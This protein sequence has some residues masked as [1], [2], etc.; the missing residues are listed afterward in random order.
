[1][2]KYVNFSLSNLYYFKC[3]FIYLKMF[4]YFW[5]SWVFVAAQAFLQLWQVGTTL[6]AEPELLIVGIC[7]CGAQPLV[8][9]LQSLQRLASVLEAPEVQSIVSVVLAHGL[10]LPCDMW[11]LPGSGIKPVPPAVAGRFFTTAPPGK[12]YILS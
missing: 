6:A 10:K 4:V 12:P 5:V 9:G 7:P 3:I 1:M 11:D 8:L 2:L